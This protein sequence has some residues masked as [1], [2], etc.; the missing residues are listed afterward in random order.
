LEPIG[1]YLKSY[2][3]ALLLLAESR[4][5][6]M[7]TGTGPVE[8]DLEA[9]VE[10]LNAGEPY[11]AFVAQLA[12]AHLTRHGALGI[13]GT[14]APMLLQN[15]FTDDVFP[16]R[17][18]LKLYNDLHRRFENPDVVLLMGDYGHSRSANRDLAAEA[19]ND[20]ATEFF[21]SRLKDEGDGPAP[22]S[23]FVYEMT[24]PAVGDDAA[25]ER[26]PFTAPSWRELAPE[27]VGFGAD[28]VQTVA[29][30]GGDP[31]VGLNFDPI[32]QTNPLFGTF[33]PCKTVPPPTWPPGTVATADLNVDEAFTMAGLPTIRADVVTVGSFGQLN[34][35]LYDVDAE[36]NHRLI[37]R[38]TY[39][40]EPNQS[41][42]IVFQLQ[43]NAYTFE[44][45]RTIL[46]E[47]APSDAPTFRQ[48][49]RPFVVEVT[50]LSIELPVL[51]A[52]SA[53]GDVE[54]GDGSGG[55]GA[56]IPATGGGAAAAMLI[57]LTSASIV[58]RRRVG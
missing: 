58:R 31:S 24:C 23:V 12:E 8:W 52:G 38:G 1:V 56:A 42:E 4:G 11:D 14:P 44:A 18:G 17:E 22:G 20:I 54:G 39:R 25:L 10:A 36:G 9:I 35:R 37:T 6:V 53:P 13:D 57:A 51:A 40:L 19:F 43:G 26:G 21:N 7:N 46:L 50:D 29:W 27:R 33:D 16:P 55:G 2:M 5:Y 49:D 48:P 32:P 30:L 34:G 45:G 28:G 15:G 41:G 3:D 47:L